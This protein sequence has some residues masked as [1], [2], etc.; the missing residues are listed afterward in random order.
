M[1]AW[2]NVTAR[3]CARLSVAGLVA[4]IVALAAPSA[5]A[6]LPTLAVSLDPGCNTLDAAA[7]RRVLDVEVGN[8]VALTTEVEGASVTVAVTCE[9]DIAHLSLDE[10]ASELPTLARDVDLASMRGPS[11]LIAL[12]IAELLSAHWAR[13]A[14]PEAPPEPE[15]EPELERELER[16]PERGPRQA[17]EPVAPAPLP[18]LPAAPVGVRAF[19]VL[20][21]AGDPAHAWGGGGLALDVSLVGP[22]VLWLDVRATHGTLE[23]ASSG[24]VADT[25]VSG[26]VLVALRVAMDAGHLDVGLG[27]RAGV[28]ILE[29]RQSAAA[30]GRA[31]VGPTLGPVLASALSL[32]LASPV[33]FH[34]GLEIGWSALGV[35]GTDDRGGVVAR[36]GGPEAALSLGVEVRP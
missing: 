36:I 12:A 28:G 14:E 20:G 22:L 19:A 15:P 24:T 5:H 3:P 18:E 23:A 32:R 30:D 6:Q 25:R 13:R 1:E 10:P 11:R 34:I 17:S 21:V 2:S 29:G 16:E 26:A 7:M 9:G 33:F 4:A 27:A 31:L 8:L 35:V